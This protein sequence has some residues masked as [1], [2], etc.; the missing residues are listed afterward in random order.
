MPQFRLSN[1][2]HE[3]NTNQLL[4]SPTQSTIHASEGDSYIPFSGDVIEAEA[5]DFL[6]NICKESDPCAIGRISHVD[7]VDY[8]LSSQTNITYPYS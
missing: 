4:L 5:G 3:H 2:T 8:S 1:N 6:I 7:K